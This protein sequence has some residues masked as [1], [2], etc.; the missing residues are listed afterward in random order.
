MNIKKVLSTLLVVIWMFTIFGFSHQQGTGSSN[1]SK[2][3]SMAIVNIL[4]I[5]NQM[6]EEQKEEIVQ[7][8]EPIIRK[9][10]HL[11]IYMIGGILLINCVYTYATENKIAILSSSIIG[12]I[13]AASDELHQLFVNGRSGRLIDVA[14]DSIGVFIGIAIYL[15]VRKMVKCIVD[16]KDK[17]YNKG[18]E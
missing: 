3:V 8:I 16:R 17:I 11:T 12:V 9:L 1:T 2:K 6:P 4:D 10:A 14:I 7:V 15:L 5:R 18:G 13:Y